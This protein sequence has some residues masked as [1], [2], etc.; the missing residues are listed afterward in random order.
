MR[1][2]IMQPYLFPYLGYFQLVN[3]AE[4]FIIYDDV[5]FIKQG[6]IN[7]NRILVNGESFMFTVPVSNIS[8]YSLIRETEINYKQDWKTKLLRTITYNYK[9][10][11][12]FEPAFAIVEN[13][14]GCNE[15]YISE[16]ATKSI[17]RI[18]D[19]IG[20]KS[21]ITESATIY[22]NSDLAA[23]ERVLDICQRHNATE[24]LNA[25]GGMELYDAGSFGERGIKLHFIKPGMISYR[26]FTNSFIPNLS[27]IDVIMFNSPEMVKSML[28]EYELL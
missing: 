16:L 27:I 8:S 26:Q 5:T 20:I 7:R 25:P 18:S 21:K 10:A 13:I 28:S 22:K 23:E 1:I 24:Y 17:V 9:K 4:E 12:Y 3:A 11:P 15:K 2:A 6:W 19:Y 14:F